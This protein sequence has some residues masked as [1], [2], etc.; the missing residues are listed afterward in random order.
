MSAKPFDAREPN[1]V[2]ALTLA[3]CSG[4]LLAD[5]AIAMQM[6]A[7]TVMHHVRA[8]GLPDRHPTTRTP[9]DDAALQVPP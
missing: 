6:P 5:I 2:E 4:A 9:Y 3:W 1:K 8:L 7:A